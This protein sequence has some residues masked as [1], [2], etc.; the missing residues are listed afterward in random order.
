MVIPTAIVGIC[1]LAILIE[2]GGRGVAVVVQFECLLLLKIVNSTTEHTTWNER[3]ATSWRIEENT[4]PIKY[5]VKVSQQ[6]FAERSRRS[7]SF[8][9]IW[10]QSRASD[11]ATERKW[12]ELQG[13]R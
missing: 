12:K 5:T 13:E 10:M 7:F 11:K 8:Q 1:S 2:S 9:L 4:L 3:K 6:T